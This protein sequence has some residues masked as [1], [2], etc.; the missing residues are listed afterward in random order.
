MGEVFQL[1]NSENLFH[2][3]NQGD[4]FS[5]S[6]EFFHKKESSGKHIL[7]NRCLN[8]IFFYVVLMKNR[9]GL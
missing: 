2:K 5:I 7:K 4:K 8:F 9:H 3:T 1:G 6:N